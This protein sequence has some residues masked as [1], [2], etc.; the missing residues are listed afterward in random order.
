[1][2]I[3]T[4]KQIAQEL[5]I[6]ASTV[7]RAINGKSVVKEET[8]QMVLETARKYAY[9]PNE[10][11][12]SLQ[13]S[14]TKTIAVVLPDISETFFGTIVNEIDRVVARQGYMLLLA[15][16]HEKVEKEQR[17]LEMLYTR[18][19][20]ALVLAT[21]DCSGETV[22]RFL[23]GHTPV[24]FIDNVPDVENVDAITIDNR[25]ASRLAIEHLAGYGHRRIAAI[26]GSEK[27]TTGAERL[28]GYREA[29]ADLGVAVDERLIVFGD[30]KQESGY[31]CMKRLLEQRGEAPFSAVYVISEKMTYGAVKA[32]REKGL[33]IP[34]DISVVG[35]D[36]HM[37]GIEQDQKI[38][39]VRQ[40]E[41]EIGQK[42]GEL[43][44]RCLVNSTED[45]ETEHKQILLEPFLEEGTTVRRILV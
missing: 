27:E 5:G 7:S 36:I 35:F 20:D 41:K 1:M 17:Y 29:L 13:K 38:T 43:L 24:V 12:R 34:E 22:S 3:T 33:R 16:T 31:Q 44:L 2:K 23:D 4:I 19:V 45:E 14:S 25:H 15:D 9:T 30:Y 21:I 18:R 11:A 28:A 26:I 10:I 42:V 40:P 37:V 6:S 8:R 32:I 39:T